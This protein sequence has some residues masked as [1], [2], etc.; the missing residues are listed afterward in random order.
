MNVKSIVYWVTTI[1]FCA[2]LTA[3]GLASVMHTE[4][5]VESMTGLG[6]PLYFLTIIGLAK[7]LGVVSLLIPANPLLKEW[8]YAGFT[9]NL[10]GASASRVFAGDATSEAIIPIVI[11]FVGALSYLFRPALRR[12]PSSPTLA[13]PSSVQGPHQPTGVKLR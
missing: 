8:A 2:V 3:S 9:F 12:L 10:L 13:S 4:R 6:Y 7:L 11:L 1:L 5:M